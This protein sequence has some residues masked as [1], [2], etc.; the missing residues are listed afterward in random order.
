M[1]PRRVTLTVLASAVLVLPS[2]PVVA[3]RTAEATY[4]NSSLVGVCQSDGETFWEIYQVGVYCGVF[5]SAGA[6]SSVRVELADA[7]ASGVAGWL[8]FVDGNGDE[9][10]LQ[11]FCGSGTA[12]IPSN[13]E[14]VYVTVAHQAQSDCPPGVAGSVRFELT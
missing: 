7:S 6:F 3:A 9:T 13:A 1:R 11:P 4:V 8:S 10:D 2:A 12:A 14:A 5:L